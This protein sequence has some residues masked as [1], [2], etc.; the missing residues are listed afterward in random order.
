M[1][2]SVFKL[3]ELLFT[4]LKAF[5]DINIEY[6]SLDYR[7]IILCHSLCIFIGMYV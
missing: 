1:D 4:I 3:F 5:A 2:D 7:K 6:C